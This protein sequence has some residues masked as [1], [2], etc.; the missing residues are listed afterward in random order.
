[1]R[2]RN[3]IWLFW[4]IFCTFFQWISLLFNLGYLKVSV[5]AHATFVKIYCHFYQNLLLGIKGWSSPMNILLTSGDTPL[6]SGKITMEEASWITS[7]LSVGALI[8]NI[9]FGYISNNFGRKIPLLVISIPMIVRI[10]KLFPLVKSVRPTFRRMVWASTLHIL[11]SEI[12]FTRKT[13]TQTQC[14]FSSL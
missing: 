3:F 10:W 12:K 13:S 5:I 4:R 11:S 9:V 8:C 1:M 6:P 2:K 14:V 7:L